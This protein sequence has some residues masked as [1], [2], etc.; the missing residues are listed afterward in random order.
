M[1]T[2]EQIRTAHA[3]VRSGADFPAFIQEI[4][5]LGVHR[6]ETFVSD[7]HT[8]YFGANDYKA[9]TP[10]KYTSLEISET[11][12]V[13]QFKTELKAHQ[14]GKS[15]YL[16][17]C[18]IAARMGVEKWVVDLGKMTCTYYDKAKSVMLVEEIP[19]PDP[20]AILFPA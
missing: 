14:E 9:S 3:K 8:D 18:N 16:I 2:V 11:S 19:R 12:D 15:D 6:Y 20:S 5:K 10:A 1:F 13:A 17:F 7:G 4:E